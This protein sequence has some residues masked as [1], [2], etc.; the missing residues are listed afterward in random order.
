M[1]YQLRN[2]LIVIFSAVLLSSCGGL[3]SP[4]GSSETTPLQVNETVSATDTVTEPIYLNN[5]GNSA[6]AEQIS[7][8][9]QTV[10]VEGAAQIGVSIEFVQASVSG[11]YITSN[12][13]K[14]SQTVIASPR[15]NMKFVLLWT[16]KINE[17]V[18]GIDGRAGQAS[19]R[20]RVPISVEQVSAD[21]LGCSDN[22]TDQTTG[23]IIPESPAQVVMPTATLLPVPAPTASGPSIA[24]SDTWSQDGI[25]VFLDQLKLNSDGISGYVVV[26]NQT[27]QSLMFSVDSRNFALTDNLGNTGDVYLRNRTFDIQQ[28]LVAGDGA[29]KL[30]AGEK[31]SIDITFT[32]LN[33]GNSSVTYAI[34]SIKELSRATNVRW[35][36]VIPH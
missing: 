25:D 28:I 16:E 4:S 9:S 30:E 36:I 3:T 13:V 29:S 35:Q 7:E 33:F 12:S 18:V 6:Q 22:S 20:V 21:D 5:C 34:L 26:N 2:I 11:Q 23:E 1:R 17:G 19:Y 8:R 31:M 14:K 15:T 27:G 32:G 10:S 24:A